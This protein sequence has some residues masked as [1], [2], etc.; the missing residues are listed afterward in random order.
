MCYI[1]GAQ[2]LVTLELADGVT[3]WRREGAHT[4]D[5]QVSRC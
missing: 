2:A 1:A 4:T 3:A 5:L